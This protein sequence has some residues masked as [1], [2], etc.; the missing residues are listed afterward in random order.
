MKVNVVNMYKDIPKE[1]WYKDSKVGLTLNL[2]MGRKSGKVSL[3][4]NKF[5]TGTLKDK[6]DN[7]KAYWIALGDDSKP[8]QKL[9]DILVDESVENLNLVCFCKSEPNVGKDCHC[10]VIQ[11]WLIEEDL[12]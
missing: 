8:K 9:L 5:S 11:E 1:H 6:I 10:D 2:Y 3:F 12:I 4:G 7:H